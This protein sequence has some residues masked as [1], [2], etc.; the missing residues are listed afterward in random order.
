[1]KYLVQNYNERWKNVKLKNIG[2]NF[3]FLRV[4]EGLKK[5]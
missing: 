3:K 4:N 5:K 2:R 1:M